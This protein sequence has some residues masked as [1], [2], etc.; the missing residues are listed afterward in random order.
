MNATYVRTDRKE[1]YVQQEQA[2]TVQ[3][4]II[5]IFL[6]FNMTVYLHYES[7]PPPLLVRPLSFSLHSCNFV[8]FARSL[9]HSFLFSSYIYINVLHVCGFSL[10]P[11]SFRS[12]SYL[13]LGKDIESPSGTVGI[14]PRSIVIEWKDDWYRRMKRFQRRDHA[15]G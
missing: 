7:P 2:S 1:N 15:C 14:G 4:G 6:I 9:Y 10:S 8:H 13:I 11:I 5:N 3:I 12:R